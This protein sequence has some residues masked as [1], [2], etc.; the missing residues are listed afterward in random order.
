MNYSMDERTLFEQGKQFFEAGEILKAIDCGE[1]IL[2][3]NPQHIDT[4][5]ALIMCYG[6][7]DQMPAL[8]RTL[9]E[10]IEIFP[11]A[12]PF[13]SSYL[14]CLN[15]FESTQNFIFKEHRTRL[16]QIEKHILN[17]NIPEKKSAVGRK[18]R[19]GYLGGDFRMHACTHLTL[20]LL[21]LH[22]RN[23][24]DIFLYSNNPENNTTTEEFK[25]LGEWRDIRNLPDEA[26]ATLI[27]QDKIDILVDLSGHTISG[28]VSLLMRRPAPLQISWYGYLNTMGT[29]AL[30]HRFTDE[31]LILSDSDQFYTENLIRL[32]RAFL[33][34][35]HPETPLVAPAPYIKNGF[36]TFGAL[37]NIKKIN[38]HSLDLWCMILKATPNSKL[39]IN[40]ETGKDI[41]YIL[42]KR[43]ADRGVFRKQLI[44]E[45][46]R[47]LP[48]YFDFF[49][50]FDLGLDTF[51]YTS[52]VSA[53]HGIWMGAPTLTIEG[54][55]ELG[56]NCSAVNKFR[57]LEEFVAHS[58]ADFVARAL[59]YAGNP[60][61]LSEFRK[62]CRTRPVVENTVVVRAVEEAYRA[63]SSY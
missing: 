39:L 36:F 17:P 28:R 54:S 7:V 48:H 37:H 41:E 47:T 15:Y 26:A 12:V 44:F 20:P 21:K 9:R 18:I 19:I 3:K 8:I 63:L 24:F 30:T 31:L 10:T 58:D 25:H 29:A 62:T 1:K 6:L 42:E 45:K 59:A 34:E 50:E 4:R 16:E 27:Q 53:M 35:P 23:D 14:F 22:N 38:D 56:R 61:T 33:Y 32:P 13:T 51:P 52:G 57:G 46:D 5:A 49:G 60:S 2:Q 40:T 11:S 55:T 43:F